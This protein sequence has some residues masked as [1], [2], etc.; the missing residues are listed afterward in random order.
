M[1]TIVGVVDGSCT[2][3]DGAAAS[4]CSAA[5]CSPGYHTFADGVGCTMNTCIAKANTAAWTALGC[6]VAGTQDGTTVAAIG[7][8]SGATG[9]QSCAVTCPTNN[10][11]FVVTVV[12]NLVTCDTVG[13]SASCAAAPNMLVSNF[14]DLGFLLFFIL[15]FIACFITFSN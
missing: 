11:A 6:V 10:G 1:D 8:P 13:G 14:G 4:T 7:T 12:S 9:Y 3:C 15:C 2:A 5:T